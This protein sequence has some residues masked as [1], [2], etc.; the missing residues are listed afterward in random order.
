MS[1]GNKK[2]G[3]RKA[4]GMWLGSVVVE[5]KAIDGSWIDDLTGK[6]VSP[7]TPMV[8]AYPDIVPFAS[9]QWGETGKMEFAQG[10]Q[11]Q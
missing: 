6:S 3:K 4:G 8:S 11:E 10:G 2:Q 7:D 9:F 1:R 5:G